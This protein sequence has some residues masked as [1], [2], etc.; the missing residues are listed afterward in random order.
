ME[1]TPKQPGARPGLSDSAKLALCWCAACFLAVGLLTAADISGGYTFTSGEKNITH[2]KLNSLGAGT[3]NPTFITDKSAQTAVAADSFLYYAN[4]DAAFRKTTLATLFANAPAINGLSTINSGGNFSV[5]T[6]KFTVNATTGDS[7]VAGSLTVSSNAVISATKNGAAL[8]ITNLSSGASAT[9]LTLYGGFGSAPAFSVLS[10][11][12]AVTGV[13]SISGNLTLGAGYTTTAAGQLI[14]SNTAAFY[15]SSTVLGD[16][17]SDTITINGTLAGTL[18]GAP[19]V[20]L[21]NATPLTTDKFLFQASGDSSK[22]RIGTLPTLLNT[23]TTNGSI[24]PTAVDVAHGLGGVPDSVSFLLVC[25]NAELG[26]SVG[27]ELPIYQAVNTS[28]RNVLMGGANETNVFFAMNVLTDIDIRSKT[29]AAAGVTPITRT[30]W[31]VRVRAIK[32][33]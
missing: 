29:N 28:E 12:M 11:G 20:G 23:F 13:S 2:T 14:A 24:I 8:S 6:D 16:A 31:N 25:T 27:D 33:P 17:A 21:T 19:V 30:N 5:N 10:G 4:A 26:F 1:Q 15:G 9:A 3:I 22:L 32:K 18:Y 7:T